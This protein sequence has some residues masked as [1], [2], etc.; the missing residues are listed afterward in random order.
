MGD[1]GI[2]K[3]ARLCQQ[4]FSS[5]ISAAAASNVD[6]LGETL[7]PRNVKQLQERFDQWAGNLGARQP[8]TSPLSL[9]HRLRNSPVVRDAVLWLLGNLLDSLVSATDIATGR[10]PNRRADPL[11]DSGIDL[12]EYDL[13]SSDSDSDCDSSHSAMPSTRALTATSEIE[14]LM[15][16]IKDGIDSLFRTSIF[17]RKHAPKDR[18]QR[19]SAAKPFDNR[20]DVMYV[21]DRYPLAAVKNEALMAR[22]GEA[23][24]RRRQYFKYCRDHKERLSNLMAEKTDAQ[25]QESQPDRVPGPETSQTAERTLSRLSNTNPSL[26]ADTKATEF[27]AGELETAQSSIQLEEQS[28]RS[29]VSFATTVAEPSDAELGFPP[30]PPEAKSNSMFLCPYCFT[31]VALKGKDREHQWRSVSTRLNWLLS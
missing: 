27:A 7:N 12:A 11:I 14:E 16:A 18:R 29:V 24:A 28:T 4:N 5:L 15:L 13:S 25:K 1:L 26:L 21:K 22:L 30:L 3:T 8:A 9:E 2:S 19:A 17:V 6:D 10:R 20:A 31:V 23:N